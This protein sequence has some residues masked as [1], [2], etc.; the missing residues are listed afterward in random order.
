[1]SDTFTNVFGM[2]EKSVKLA[3]TIEAAAA[4][5]FAVSF[6]SKTA[7]RLGSL[8][9]ISVLSVAAY[10]HFEAGHGKRCSTCIR[11]IRLSNIELIRYFDGKR[12]Y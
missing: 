5:L 11:L 8:A 12:K 9:T 2:P 4:G 7:S 6:L 10:K 3:G 1:M